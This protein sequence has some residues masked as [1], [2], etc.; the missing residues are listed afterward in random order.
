M[1]APGSFTAGSVLTAAEMNA[2][3]GGL[4]GYVRTSTDFTVT[5]G[6]VNIGSVT[7]TLPST[8]LV[9]FGLHFSSIDNRSTTNYV[10]ALVESSASWFSGTS[11][12]HAVST[13][14]S[15]GFESLS[16]WRVNQMSAGTYTVYLN[17]G[18][19]TGTAQLNGATGTGSRFHGLF[20]L[21]MGEP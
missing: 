20:V 7:F 12:L 14:T 8:R 11:Y 3:P 21:D 13:T 5:T 17:S 6:G 15:S 9:L 16:G 19:N 18:T 10:A 2:L 1:A 4:L